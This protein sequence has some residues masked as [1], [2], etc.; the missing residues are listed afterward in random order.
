MERRRVSVF[1]S[2]GSIG[3]NTLDLL[4]RQ[5]GA[6]SYEVVALTGGDNIALLAAQ[7]REM[8]AEIA[9]TARDDNLAALRQ[10]LDGSD[11]SAAAGPAALCEAAARPTAWSMS[12]IGGCAGLEPGLIALQH[13]GILALANKESLVA[14]GQ[15]LPEAARG[16]GA[17]I[18]PVD[19]EHSAIYQALVGEDIGRL[20]RMI[21]TA[22]G[23]PFRDWSLAEL[24]RATPE[25]ALAHPNWDMG[26]MISV[27]SASMFNKA[28]EMIEAKEFY[29]VRSDQIEVVVHPQ[30]VIHSLVGFVDGSMMA[31]M[32]TPD[33]RFAIGY[34]LN[35]PE[36]LDL[37]VAP[38]NLAELGRL[39][40]QPPDETRFPA[41]RLA[42]EVMT[43]GGLSGAAFNAA[44]EAAYHAFMARQIG[45]TAMA[46]IVEDVLE[47]MA[48]DGDL[49]A[50]TIDLDNVLAVDK[51]ARLR[52]GDAIETRKAS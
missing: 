32:G 9:V 1:G 33:M 2:T 41:L 14:G 50:A 7:A 8:R 12:A 36:R 31:H 25:Q 28:L 19:S 15:L 5:G 18:L 29:G 24:H 37:P 30:S 27:D 49:T 16:T 6:D 21:L 51:L 35:W 26:R 34:A 42:R 43:R 52:A 23:G 47:R 45:F 20:D 4:R 22:S 39:D 17:T 38:L 10:A 13:G 11:V 3:Q 44:K 48:Q 40:F 46:R